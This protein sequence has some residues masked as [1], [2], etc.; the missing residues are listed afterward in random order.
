MEKS[1]E[2]NKE[3]KTLSS[4]IPK[5]VPFI[6]SKMMVERFATTGTSGKYLRVLRGVI[7]I[8]YS[9]VAILVLYLNRKLNPDTSTAIFHTN[10]L[11]AYLFPIFGAIVADSWWGHFKTI[12]WMLLL[13]T[14]GSII[15][16]VGSIDTLPLPHLLVL[17]RSTRD[18]SEWHFSF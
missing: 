1:I 8:K 7:F 15:V 6:L 4:E 3:D 14:I 11:L 5:E 18:G 13:F 16:F 2:Q 9:F 12:S 17:R 10:E